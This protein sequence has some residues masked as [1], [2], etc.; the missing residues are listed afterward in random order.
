MQWRAGKDAMFRSDDSPL[1]AED[2]AAF[3]GLTYFPYDS[4]RTY[5]V[6]LEPILEPDTLR[7]STTTGGLRA[8]VRFGRL[9]FRDQQGRPHHLT[10][11]RPADGADYLFVPFYDATNRTDTYGGGRYL[12][13]PADPQGRYVL[14]F[15]YAYS[16]FCVF[17]ATYSCPV[18]P[19]ENRLE[20][21]IRA[22]ER[23]DPNRFPAGL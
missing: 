21:P 12:E 9:T 7:M 17:D 11:Y 22:G 1:P 6:S 2:R 13:L 3:S 23:Y 19:S 5:L 15:N 14:D 4:T 18:P 8:Y 20:A 10:A 16:P